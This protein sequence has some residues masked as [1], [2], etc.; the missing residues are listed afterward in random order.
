MFRRRHINASTGERD[1]RIA[2]VIVDAV[3]R[4]LERFAWGLEQRL[5]WPS[6]DL[7]R[8]AF[9]IV[10]WPF[11]RLV[12]V[13][14]RRLVW[15]L[16]E[17]ASDLSRPSRT[18][19]AVVAVATA[20]GLLAVISKS[21]NEP[22]RVQVAAPARVV[23]AA[24]PPPSRAPAPARPVLQGVA[25][26]FNAEGNTKVTETTK[27]VLVEADAG[28]TAS[29]GT[30][31]DTGAAASSAKPVP[32]GPVAMKAAR[33][34]AEAFVFY[35]IGE[36]QERAKTVFG[37]TATPRLA[38]ALGERP[39]RLPE[40]SK[41][42]QARVLNLVPGPRRGNAFTVSVSLLRVGV[43]SELRLEMKKRDGAWLVTDV[44]G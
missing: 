35:E 27:G 4:P 12:W 29:D 18:A 33:R 16:H 20:V 32:V 30:A 42:P 26:S 38:G 8:G 1:A 2:F 6:G 11:E 10:K 22:A 41:V 23:V 40:S 3:R 19:G 17:R 25:P 36:R 34:F 37:E 13:T 9:D 31:E 7:L 44:R 43:T 5:V 24:A 21:D 28:T 14:E 39:P 15:P